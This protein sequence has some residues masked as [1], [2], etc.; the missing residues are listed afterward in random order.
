MAKLVKKKGPAAE[1]EMLPYALRAAHAAADYKAI[2]LVAYDLRGLTL[3]A[4]CFI[5]CSAASEPQ[6]K[7][8][9]NGVRDALRETGLR[10]RHVEGE[11]NSGWLV[12]DYGSLIFHV[13]REEARAFYDLDGLWGD[14]PH[15]ALDLDDDHPTE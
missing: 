13:F 1:F 7:A 5:V 8:I 15:I 2:D 4:D 9:T 3:I 10:P 11:P 14:A 12:L 6:M